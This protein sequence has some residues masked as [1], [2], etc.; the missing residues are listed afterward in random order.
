VILIIGPA[1]AFAAW[2]SAR[3]LGHRPP[4]RLAITI[5]LSVLTL[6]YFLG[7]VGTGIFWVA[8]QELPVFDWHY[9]TGYLLLAL[10]ATHV[11][12][13][14]RNIAA[15]LRRQSPPALLEADGRRFAAWPRRLAQTVAIGAGLTLV[16]LLGVRQGSR[17]LTL[18]QRTDPAAATSFG[19][20]AL[21]PVQMVEAA[22]AKLPLA[23]LYHQGSSYPA[24]IGLPGLTVATRPPAYLDLPG[25][26]IPLPARAP[27]GDVGV[28]AAFEAWRT[29]RP[30][31]HPG[32][33][34]LE[35]LASLLHHAQGV[36]STLRR[37]SGDIDLRMAA[38]AGALYPV[39]VYLAAEEVQGLA[40]GFYY[41]HP[42]KEALVRVKAERYPASAV[43]LASGA[44]GAFVDAP[45]ALV[46]T[47]TF[48]RTAFKYAER[49]YRYV[50]MDTGHVAYNLSVAA[51]ASGWH[52]PMVARFDDQ[53][54]ET[55]LGLDRAVEAP[56]LVIPLAPK[57]AAQDEPRFA[58]DPRASRRPT[59]VDLIHGATSLRVAGGRA[60]LARHPAVP[61]PASADEVVLPPPLAGSPLLPTIR[62]RRSMRKFGD[63]PV[64]LAELSTLLSSSGAEPDGR[65]SSDPLLAATAPLQLYAVVRRVSGL[66]P[67]VY[68]YRPSA[69]ALQLV[70]AGERARATR[71]A[72]LDQDFC[73]TA[74]VVF[75]KTVRW[76]DLYLPDGDRGYRYANLRA[77]V[78][79][80]GLYLA[81]TALG[82][83]PC[84]V[85]AFGDNDVAALVGLDLSV[86]V[87][88]YLTAVGR[89]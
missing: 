56:L 3:A 9:L 34:T 53:A 38:S 51:A 45:A 88:I 22:G 26:V 86:E 69:H 35:R 46:F 82:L 60:P 61:P 67:G 36:S 11:V 10:T 83:G 44:P 55:A 27:D 87:P 84:G 29:G 25:E 13:H 71:E 54:L 16:F 23:H 62:A 48:G 37:P 72:C 21:V 15:F 19:R 57:V 79:G 33:L 18:L 52:A 2:L 7:V 59:F 1:L 68:R 32:P 5:G 65:P 12:L 64:T 43:G 77:G 63:T 76:Q 4:Q 73:G 31:G 30:L 17:H 58:S 89:P 41:Y 81:A 40:P 66:A 42:K 14:W 8:A 80:E 50:A 39:N 85:G 6:V 70:R 20:G 28:L 49:A 75:V 24:R 74:G 78:T 47:V